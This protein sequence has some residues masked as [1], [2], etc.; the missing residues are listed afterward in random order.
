M[1]HRGTWRRTSHPSRF[2]FVLLMLVCSP[3][4]WAQSPAELP[5][6]LAKYFAPPPEFANDFGT[7]RSPLLFDDGTKV[8]TASDWA[9][10]REGI[11]NKWTKLLGV[12]PDVQ[13][14]PKVDVLAEESRDGLVQQHLKIEIAPGMFTSDAF[15]IKPPGDEPHPGVVVVYYDAKTGLGLGK[16]ALRD[17][18]FQ[19]AKRGFVA[20]SLG[21]NPETYYPDKEHCEI[22]PLAFHAYEAATCHAVLANLKEV[23]AKRIGIVGHSYGGKW[24]MFASCLFEQFACAA[25]SDGGIVFD[26][27]RG[28]VNYW[29]RWYLGY[30]KGKP[31][32]KP[33][34]PNEANPRTG[35]YF[36]MIEDG[37]DLHEL[38]AL[39]APRPFLVSG[40][41][42]DPVSRWQALNHSLAV[43]KILGY[44]DRVAMTNRPTHDPTAESNEQIYEFFEHFLKA[45]SA[46]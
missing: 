41:S 21:S 15:L 24:A 26:E 30:E 6:A 9:V 2:V 45:K 42:E 20:L 11:R 32:R 44:S 31:D 7:Y 8:A 36:T 16:A 29:E 17:F 33:G 13:V 28:N 38:H 1:S 43:N 25:W 19:L 37:F 34:I 46:N 14:K 23:D 5:P 27:S 22:Q 10:R 3:T 39:M 12:W 40:G 18:A 4:L 35:A